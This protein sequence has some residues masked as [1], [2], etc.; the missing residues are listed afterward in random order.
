MIKLKRASLVLA[1]AGACALTIALA[2]PASADPGYYGSCPQGSTANCSTPPVKLCPSNGGISD[3]RNPLCVYLG[4]GP[5]RAD[6]TN[7]G[8][9]HAVAKLSP[10]LC[11]HV[12]VGTNGQQQYDQLVRTGR[13]SGHDYVPVSPPAGGVAPCACPT[14]A[15][16]I[17]PSTPAETVPE[18]PATAPAPTIVNNNTATSPL[19]AV[20]H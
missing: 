15:P 7:D 1:G 19:P 16:V 2:V 20:T 9:L 6:G 14:P 4:P 11:A 12:I 13:C 17:V 18:A 10:I 3:Q 8:D 5:T